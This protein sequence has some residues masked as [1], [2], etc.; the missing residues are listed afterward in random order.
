MTRQNPS[1]WVHETFHEPV[2]LSGEDFMDLEK[3]R[4]TRWKEPRP[5]NDCMELNISSPMPTLLDKLECNGAVSAHCSLCLLGLSDFLPQPPEQLG[6][7][8]WGFHRVGQANL[9]LL[10]SGDRP[11][12]AS[13]SAGITAGTTG[14]YCKIWLIFEILQRQGSPY[15]AQ[16]DLEF[17]SLSLKPPKCWDYRQGLIV[18]HSVAQDGM[19]WAV[20]AHCSLK[21]PGSRIFLLQSPEGLGPQAR[22]TTPGYFLI[23]IFVSLT[24]SPRLECSGM[25]LA[26]CNLHLLGSSNSHASASR[27]AEITGTWSLALLPRLECSGAISDHCNLHLPGSNDSP[28]SP[29]RVARIT[30]VCHHA[31]LIF[32]FLVEPGFHHVGQDGLELL[33]SG[34]LPTLASQSA[35]IIGVNHRGQ[36][37][38]IFK[39]ESQ[40]VAQV[41]VQW[42]NLGSLQPPTLRLK[43]R[44]L[45][46]HLACSLHHQ[47]LWLKQSF[48]PSL[49]SSSDHRCALPCP[50]DFFFVE[51]GSCYVAQT[52]LELLASSHPPALAFQ[53]GVSL[54]CP[55]WSAVVRSQLTATSISWGQ[56]RALATLARLVLKD[57]SRSVTR[58]KCSGTILAHCNLCLP[59]STS[60]SVGIKGVSYCAG[61]KGAVLMLT[62]ALISGAV[63]L[64]L[65][66]RLEFNDTILAHCN[67]CSQGLALSPSLECSGVILAYHN[68]R[69]LG[70]KTGF[71]HVVKAGLELLTSDFHWSSVALSWLTAASV[72]QVQVILRIPSGWITGVY[73]HTQIFFVLVF[74]VETGFRH[75]GQADFQLLAS[76]DPPALASQ[77]A[78]I[79]GDLVL[80]PR[81]KCSGIILVHCRL[82]LP[83]LKQTSPPLASQSARRSC[84][85]A[86]ARVQWCNHRSLQ[87]SPPRLK[88]SSH[89]SLQ[90]SWDYRLECNS[91]ISAHHN[92]CFPGSSD[93]ASAS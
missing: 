67:L 49:L 28:A 71:Q 60:Q 5:L 22:T 12:S 68:L 52:G 6:L 40:F 1:G 15:V 29:S 21:L 62:E 7:Q 88:R 79:T 50:V 10:T 51:M 63:S 34:D 47:F 82:D 13:Q 77:S 36:P 31:W 81:V 24:L 38:S 89:F 85:V 18:P 56:R 45:L 11:A 46:Y 41:G 17:L 74:L 64:I 69:L 80:L 42:H 61:P 84:S 65:L 26:Y 35:G 76:S 43:D 3:G 93:T 87:P 23:F 66:P 59:G 39:M 4:S 30:G 2:Q 90:S 33:T 25:I 91:A 44:V 9:E 70:S 75:V 19:Q 78:A 48:H 32:V 14:M 16:A 58:M 73:H 53:K 20:I 57:E 55:G 37:H 92:L 72:S 54:C 8:R 27:V 86:Q 83:G